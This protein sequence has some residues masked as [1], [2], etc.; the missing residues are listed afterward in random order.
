MEEKGLVGFY[1]GYIPNLIRVSIKQIYRWPMMIFFPRFFKKYFGDNASLN[2]ILTGITIANIEIL[3]ICPL[4]RLKVFFMTS[5]KSKNLFMYFFSVNSDRIVKEL[6][7]GL[8][9]SYWRS[10]ISWVSFLYLDQRCKDIARH[11]KKDENL[12]FMDLIGVSMFVCFGNLL[13]S[14]NI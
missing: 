7:A 2:K 3:I 8:G 12:G 5:Q 9:P 14:I 10:N 13:S 4:D 1:R 6:F 11:I